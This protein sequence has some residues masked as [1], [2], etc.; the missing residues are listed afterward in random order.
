MVGGADSARLRCR[1]L[2]K[3]TRQCR[4]W[5]RVVNLIFLSSGFPLCG[6][7]DIQVVIIVKES[8]EINLALFIIFLSLS[9][10]FFFWVPLVRSFP[11]V[12]V[13]D[14]FWIS[15]TCAD[16]FIFIGCCACF[17]GFL[18][19]FLFCFTLLGDTWHTPDK[20][21]DSGKRLGTRQ[22]YTL[23]TIVLLL[24]QQLDIFGLLKR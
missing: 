22:V 24:L 14:L 13:I 11:P 17:F 10:Y 8:G 18:F 21:D 5:V 12:L 9:F 19:C 6:R 7:N 3:W 16:T 20:M 2:V 15:T 4:A 23:T 1:R